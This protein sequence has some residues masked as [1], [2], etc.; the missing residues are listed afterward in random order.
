MDDVVKME[1]RSVTESELTEIL[2]LID[3]FD[4][5]PAPRPDTMKL[6][7]IYKSIQASGGCVLGACIDDKLVGTCTVNIC[8]NLSWSGRP[9]AMIENVIVAHGFRKQGLG[10]ALLDYA[11]KH[12]KSKGCYKVALM[13]GVKTSSVDRFYKRAGF[14]GDK[15]GY[16]IR[17]DA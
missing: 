9:Y 4:R 16:Q 12:A 6:H 8:P 1:I 7:D 15:L 5:L 13:T 17:F 14:S 3:S 10:K 2:D 11:V